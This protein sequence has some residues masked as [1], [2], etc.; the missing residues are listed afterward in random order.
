MTSKIHFLVALFG[1]VF[2]AAVIFFTAYSNLS[3]LSQYAPWLV[4]AWGAAER[5][6]YGSTQG[7]V[8]K[9]TVRTI[10]FHSDL[11]GEDRQMLVYLPP[12]YDRNVKQ[13][14]PVVYLLH[15]V[16]GAKEDWLVNAA[17]ESQLDGMIAA[18]ELPPCV[19]V[20]PDGNGPQVMDSEYVDASLVSQP[21]ESYIVSEVVP[22]VDSHFR[23]LAD[24]RYRA[25]GGLSS[26][27]Y[28]AVNIGLKHN[29]LFSVLL[30]HSGYFVNHEWAVGQLFGGKTTAWH[31]NN[32]QEYV[33]NLKLNPETSIYIEVGKIDFPDF[34]A[35]NQDFADKLTALHIE[36]VYTESD[37]IHSWSAW[38]VAI[39]QSLIYTA[40]KWKQWG[41]GGIK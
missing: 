21:M 31:A 39:R 15:G 10:T 35:G 1:G 5:F 38:R 8:F 23:T 12:G 33:G 6:Y 28:G 13:K 4:N 17:L 19:I 3:L 2:A 16:P 32:P 11:L 40:S 9:S 29:E 20:M 22:Y 41:L 25:L 18:K 36:H 27:A 7:S 24:R 26:G 37:G 34:I 14:Y 30:S